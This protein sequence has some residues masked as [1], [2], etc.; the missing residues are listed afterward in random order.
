MRMT[1]SLLKEECFVD[2]RIPIKLHSIVAK[3]INSEEEDKMENGL[4]TT[5]NS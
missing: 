2:F 5:H 1:S 3:I 4:E